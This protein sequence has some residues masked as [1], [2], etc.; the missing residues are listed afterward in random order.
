MFTNIIP[1]SKVELEYTN[2][3]THK[4]FLNAYSSFI[5]SLNYFFKCV[6]IFLFVQHFAKF[7]KHR[8]WSLKRIHSNAFGIL[9]DT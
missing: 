6:C 3:A 4:Y 9:V 7:N 5:Y 2:Q 1:T 8:K